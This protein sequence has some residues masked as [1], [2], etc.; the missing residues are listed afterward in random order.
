MVRVIAIRKYKNNI[1]QGVTTPRDNREFNNRSEVAE[2]KAR[3]N[4]ILGE[5]DGIEVELFYKEV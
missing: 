3:L 2:Y 1:Y 5:R 4:K